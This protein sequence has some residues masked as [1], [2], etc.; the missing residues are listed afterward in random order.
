MAKTKSVQ[1]H[2][3][4]A[5]GYIIPASTVGTAIAVVVSY[6]L[7]VPDVVQGSLAVLFT[8]AINLMMVYAK[9]K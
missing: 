2:I 7:D 4:S 1:E 5:S 9:K 3:K 6:Y 8:T